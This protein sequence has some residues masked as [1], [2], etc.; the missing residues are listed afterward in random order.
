MR[1]LVLGAGAVGTVIA[2][3]L[4]RSKE[5]ERIVVADIDPR[6][7]RALKK[8]IGGTK[9]VVRKADAS[10]LSDLVRVF[11]GNDMVVN[12]TVPK[13]NLIVMEACLK[14]KCHYMDLSTGGPKEVT[15]TPELSEQ[16]AYDERFRNAGLTAMLSMGVDPGTSNIF[17]RYLANRMERVDEVLIRDGDNSTVDGVSFAA[18]FSPATLI[19]ECLL[20]PTVYRDG[21]FERTEPLSSREIYVFPQPIGPLTTFLVDHEE[22]ETIPLNI[23]GIKRCDFRYALSEQFVETLK[24]LRSLGLTKDQP[25]RVGRFKVSPKD[26]LVSLL[27][28]PKDLGP[29]VKGYTCVGTEVAGV[30]NGMPKRLYMYTMASHQ[31]CYEKYGVTGTAFQ[32]GVPPAIGVEMLARGEITRKG[33]FTPE[34]L[35]PEPWPEELRRHGMPVEIMD[36]T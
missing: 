18:L 7:T 29:K 24:T 2:D 5:V 19:E 8:K 1:V 25:I 28:D 33:T 16:M 21:R 23:K 20:P 6:K 9:V 36:L 30:Q 12:A 31:E 15:D 14:A 4:S 11:K 22:V 17:A 13:Y 27:P 26:V 32:T 3:Q 34:L 10:K 35:D